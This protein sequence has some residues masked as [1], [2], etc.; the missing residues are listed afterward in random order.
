[1]Y[2]TVGFLKRIQRQLR[3]DVD[4]SCVFDRQNNSSER[5]HRGSGETTRSGWVKRYKNLRSL[6]FCV[7]CYS[8]I[9]M[10][11]ESQKNK[12]SEFITAGSSEEWV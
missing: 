3:K 6:Y 2:S 12:I 8:G 7:R 11:S 9:V 1:M 4:W 5:C 10:I